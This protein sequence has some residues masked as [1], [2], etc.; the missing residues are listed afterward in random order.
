MHLSLM[1]RIRFNKTGVNIA[2]W[3]DNVD[4]V[5]RHWAR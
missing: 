4:T 5:D 3:V 2:A 1:L